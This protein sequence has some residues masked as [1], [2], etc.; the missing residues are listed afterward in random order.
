MNPLF[1]KRNTTIVRIFRTLY[2]TMPTMT[3]YARIGQDF[4]LS[5]ETVRKIVRKT[6]PTASAPPKEGL[7]KHPSSPLARGPHKP[8]Q[9]GA[10]GGVGEVRV[11]EA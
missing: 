8:A 1:E 10:L 4:H 5:E 11:G 3:L 2:G 9:W 7:T 6:P